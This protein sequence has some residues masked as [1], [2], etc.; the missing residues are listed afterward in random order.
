MAFAP[1]DKHPG[2]HDIR[3]KGFGRGQ[4]DLQTRTVLRLCTIEL[5]EF[6]AIKHR[7]ATAFPE[8]NDEL[9]IQ[10]RTS[11]REAGCFSRRTALRSARL[12]IHVEFKDQNLLLQ[13]P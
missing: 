7:K 9:V 12:S 8:A 11:L 1:I 2:N 4:F 10:G 5:G 6:G 3:S 13:G